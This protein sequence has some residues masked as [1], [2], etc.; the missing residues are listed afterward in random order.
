MIMSASRDISMIITSDDLERA[1]DVLE[2]TEIKMPRTFSGVG[3]SDISGLIPDVIA[4]LIMKKRPVNRAEL[5]EQFIA[6]A[7]DFT[8]ERVIK[9]LDRMEYIEVDVGKDPHVITYKGPN[10]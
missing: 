1:I 10:F 5:L 9:T 4:W 3:R 2:K 7:D 8:M 6:D